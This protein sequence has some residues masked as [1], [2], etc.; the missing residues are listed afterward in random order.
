[1]EEERRKRSRRRTLKTAQIIIDGKLVIECKVRRL[2]YKDASFDVGSSVGIPD[3]F[4]LSIPIDH[5]T[6]KCRVTWRQ[7]RIIGVKFV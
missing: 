3:V 7:E 1:V 4:E 6:R 5:L 2:T